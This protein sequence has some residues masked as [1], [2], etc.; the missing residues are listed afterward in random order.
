MNGATQQNRGRSGDFIVKLKK[1]KHLFTIL[2][3]DKWIPDGRL[4]SENLFPKQAI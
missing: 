2:H 3:L 4:L 1:K